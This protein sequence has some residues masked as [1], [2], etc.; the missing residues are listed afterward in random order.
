M[1][2]SCLC[3]G[4][5]FEISGPARP[6]I[7]CHCTQC[8]K[9]SG[10]FWAASNVPVECVRLVRDGTL[11]WFDASDQAS[12][13]FCTGCGAFLFWQA[14]G[15]DTISFAPGAID[16]PTGLTVAEEW[17]LEDAGDYYSG[18]GEAAPV[19]EGACLCGANRFAL[20]GPM[21]EVTACH[22]S[23]CRKTSGHF[24]ASFDVDPAAITWTARNLRDHVSPAGGVRSF[25]PTCGSGVLFR[26]EGKVSVEAGVI[27][28]PTG[29]RLAGHI[30][31]GEKGDYYELTGGL[32]QS[33]TD[34]TQA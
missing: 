13:G 20:P 1:K 14:T 8:R 21:G 33:D 29:G 17:Y 2:G 19:L 7:L 3:G 34:G 25:C 28:N 15:A 16:G 22:C 30:F 6:V 24:S 12:R 26:K 23:Q 27:A 18:P 11:A 32:P 31:V 5:V 10:H 9:Q 4:V